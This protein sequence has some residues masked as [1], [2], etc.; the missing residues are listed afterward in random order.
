MSKSAAPQPH[1]PVTVRGQ[2]INASREAPPCFYD[3]SEHT[4]WIWTPL[5]KQRCLQV[6]AERIHVVAAAT[7]EIKKKKIEVQLGGIAGAIAT[8]WVYNSVE[9]VRV[10][11]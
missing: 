3:L 2:N 1:R 4:L 6:S 7:A 11:G 5:C 10:Q 9:D 8:G